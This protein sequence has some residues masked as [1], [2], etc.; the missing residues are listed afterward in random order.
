[1]KH[2]LIVCKPSTKVISFIIHSN[3][4]VER[5]YHWRVVH[6]NPVTFSFSGSFP[7]CPSLMTRDKCRRNNRGH[8]RKGTLNSVNYFQA[9]KDLHLS[10]KCLLNEY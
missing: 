4:L 6:K 5:G 8:Y 9:D 1:M 2:N 7:A 3:R 10:K